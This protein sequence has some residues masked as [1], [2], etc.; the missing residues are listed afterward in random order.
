MHHR[1]RTVGWRAG[2]VVLAGLLVG[3]CADG[4][5]TKSDMGELVGGAL[6]GF[7]G[8]QFGSG[9][10]QLMAT[11]LGAIGGSYLGGW[12]G[13]KL[14]ARD[15]QLLRDAANRALNG[16]GDVTWA[17]PESGN[18]G[19]VKVA[20]RYADNGNECAMLHYTVEV[21]GSAE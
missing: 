3:G 16:A 4:R 5:F 19:L 7:V 20:S 12:L 11:A 6:G 1:T 10:G 8:A 9:S 15:E 2:A 21:G 18:S 17:N 13:G 14:D